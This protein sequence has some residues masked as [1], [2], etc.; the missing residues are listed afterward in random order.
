MYFEGHNNSVVEPLV[1]SGDMCDSADDPTD[2]SFDELVDYLERFVGRWIHVIVSLPEAAESLTTITEEEGVEIARFQGRARR[3]QVED[4]VPRSAVPRSCTLWIR[5]QAPDDSGDLN[6]IEV[7]EPLL[8]S[9][10]VVA[11]ILPPVTGG[12][13]LQRAADWRATISQRGV[14]T[15]IWVA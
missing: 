15:T 9:A 14:I 12:R 1:A 2:L 3:C 7:Y 4:A 11:E 5:M 13:I 8:D 6:S 10:H